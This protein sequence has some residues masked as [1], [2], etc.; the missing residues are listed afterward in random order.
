MSENNEADGYEPQGWPND[1]RSA[2][3]F[4]PATSDEIRGLPEWW[5]T[6]GESFDGAWLIKQG[7]RARRP[8]QQAL[9]FGRLIAIQTAL[10]CIRRRVRGEDALDHIEVARAYIDELP[11]EATEARA[12]HRLLDT[13]LP[14]NAAAT[15]EELVGLAWSARRGGLH[16]AARSCALF[17]YECA[18]TFDADAAAAGACRALS[19]LAL[20]QECPRAARRWRGRAHVLSLRHVRSLHARAA[21]SAGAGAQS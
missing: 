13:L 6:V 15:A 9:C 16:L 10:T 11:L 14:F 20:M 5:D 19:D 2:W 7:R 4:E 3:R 12:L 1:K 8:E 17:A 18:I 21:D